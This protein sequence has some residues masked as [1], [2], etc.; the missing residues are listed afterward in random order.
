M[1]NALNFLIQNFLVSVIFVEAHGWGWYN[2]TEA[3]VYTKYLNESVQNPKG[4]WTDFCDIGGNYCLGLFCDDDQKLNVNLGCVDSDTIIDNGGKNI[5][6]VYFHDDSPNYTIT[7]KSQEYFKELKARV[8]RR[9]RSV[10][11]VRDI[12]QLYVNTFKRNRIA[13]LTFES[14]TMLFLVMFD[15]NPPELDMIDY[16]CSLIYTRLRVLKYRVW[17][18]EW[19]TAQ[20]VLTILSAICLFLVAFLY[21]C[22]RELR[23]NIIGKIV[24][25]LAI[26]N[27]IE[28]CTGHLEFSVIEQILGV[29]ST[30]PNT[31]WF[32]VMVY[33]TFV[34]LKY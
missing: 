2:Y 15:N 24:L 27:T 22:I 30:D 25:L 32:L 17:P 7:T 34:L 18:D 10:Y 26:T 13:P 23:N 4:K 14:Y 9:D 3:T 5:G 33:E 16:R 1:A 29:I 11:V 12:V 28:L 6:F 31:Y 20:R 21:A 8:N 19:N